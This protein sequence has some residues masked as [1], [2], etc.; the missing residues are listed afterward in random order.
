VCRAMGKE[1]REMPSAAKGL[2][3]SRDVDANVIQQARTRLTAIDTPRPR[4]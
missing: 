3:F 1:W 2:D 4:R